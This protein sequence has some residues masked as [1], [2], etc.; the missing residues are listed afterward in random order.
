MLSAPPQYPLRAQTAALILGTRRGREREGIL[1][2]WV[3]TVLRSSA[4][5]SSLLPRTSVTL[6][7]APL[8]WASCYWLPSFLLPRASTV[9][10]TLPPC[11]LLP[12]TSCYWLPSPLLR[13]VSPMLPA[14]S[15]YRERPQVAVQPPVAAPVR[16]LYLSQLPT[17]PHENM[18]S[19][20][21]FGEIGP[22]PRFEEPGRGGLGHLPALG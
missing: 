3:S 21:T 5:P 11:S 19:S 7:S 8:P 17:P 14:T 18:H 9:H 12:W 2:A 1:L 13:Q 6:F 4:L 20:P 16:T 15:P 22:A 10:S